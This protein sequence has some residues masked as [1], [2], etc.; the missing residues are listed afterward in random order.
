[1]VAFAYKKTWFI[2]HLFRDLTPCSLVE[3]S[4]WFLL[5][6]WCWL[7]LFFVHEE[8]SDTSIN[9][10]RTIPC[11]IQK[12][13]FF[14]CR[15]EQNSQ[16]NRSRYPLY[17]RLDSAVMKKRKI[18]SRV[19]VWLLHGVWIGWLHLLHLHTQLV[20]TSNY[21]NTTADFHTTNH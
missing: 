6:S 9:F 1:M 12:T 18:L 4:L 10:Y 5:A 2:Q 17:R 14:I 11:Y 19:E 15:A 21:N 7:S 13:A 3:V 16:G 8:T 20:T